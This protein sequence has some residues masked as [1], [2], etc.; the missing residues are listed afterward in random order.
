MNRFWTLLLAA[1]CLTAV[2][3]VT[4]PYN[5]DGNADGDIA[6]GDLQDFLGAYGNPFSPSEIMVG[7]STLSGYLSALESR[8]L[9]LESGKYT[10]ECIDFGNTPFC[11]AGL[12]Y[13][14]GIGLESPDG[15][16]YSISYSSTLNN[17]FE[18]SGPLWR[19]F[20]LSGPSIEAETQIKLE[21]TNIPYGGNETTRNVETLTPLY[22]GPNECVFWLYG[23]N[24]FGEAD[25]NQGCASN[26][27]MA[28]TIPMDHAFQV[29]YCSL[30]FCPYF[31][32]KDFA[33]WISQEGS[34]YDTRVRFSIN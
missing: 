4:Y 2:G 6:V 34:Y 29:R 1:S 3:Q 15:Y 19:K 16:H 13:E 21:Y 30:Y 12:G 27:S 26:E 11:P 23:S 8:I 10:F 24:G 20:R 33:L 18:A 28:N 17:N 25:P 9:E 32:R 31:T 22:T 14:E 7:D 5:P